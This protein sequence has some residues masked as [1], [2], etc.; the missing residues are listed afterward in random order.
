MKYPILMRG[1]ALAAALGM[2]GA[3][4]QTRP[5]PTDSGKGVAPPVVTDVGPAPAQERESLG[6]I[7]LHDSMVRAQRQSLFER[8]ASRTGVASVGRGVL[9][10]TMKAQRE[11]DMA[12][13]RE[14]EAVE[15]YRRGAGALT[16]K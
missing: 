1:A 14:E 13:A 12:Q 5:A 6:A 2:C 8:A 16:E 9:R 4:A 7:V 11:A 10:A 3:F 15:M